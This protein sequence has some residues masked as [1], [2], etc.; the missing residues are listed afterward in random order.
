MKKT[1]VYLVVSFILLSIFATVA[2]GALTAEEIIKRRDNNEYFDTAKVEAEMVIINRNRRIVKTMTSYAQGDNG[3]VI[4]SNPRDRGTKF[5][6]RGDDLWMFF[7]DAEDL[8]KISGHMLN[9]GIMGSDFSYQDVMES[10]KLTDLYDFERIGEEEIDGRACYVLEGTAVEG[11][12]VSYYRRKSWIDKERFV[13]LKEELYTRSGRLLKVMTV[14]KVKEI[15]GRWY[16]LESVMEDKLRKNTRT[17]FII[18]SIEFNPQIP[19][20]TFTLENLR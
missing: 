18:N 12:E 15:E 19:L 3:L 5:L 10:D 13:G 11:K 2:F 4:F 7:P 1:L 9:Q 8:V 6:K 20:G 14:T 17:E 16:P